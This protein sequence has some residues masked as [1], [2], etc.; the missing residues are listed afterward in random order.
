M[1]DKPIASFIAKRMYSK[2]AVI[3]KL[4]QEEKLIKKNVKPGMNILDI[5]C[6]PGIL[7]VEMARTVGEKGKVYALDIHP[8][9][10]EMIRNQ[11]KKNKL[12]NVFPVL[13]DSIETG[14]N[15]ESIDMI[16]I[17]NTIDMIRNKTMLV[18]EIERILK[19]DGSVYIYNK[20][21]IGFFRLGKLFEGTSILFDRKKGKTFYYLKT[22]EMKN[23]K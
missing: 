13:S 20:G 3:S 22:E 6:G 14:V 7:T 2:H 23:E 12:N 18:T 17:F 5:G 10:I 16:F 11:I 1:K 4:R 21:R 8:L 9:S 19:D 15:D